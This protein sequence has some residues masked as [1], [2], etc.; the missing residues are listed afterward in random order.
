MSQFVNHLLSNMRVRQLGGHFWQ[1]F[2]DLVIV[3]EVYEEAS[4]GRDHN[5]KWSPEVASRSVVCLLDEGGSHR[6]LVTGYAWFASAV[7]MKSKPLSPCG[8][9][10][11]T[12]PYLLQQVDSKPSLIRGL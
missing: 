5:L 9:S 2:I 10:G 11:S 6:I 3:F 12:Q 1:S 8:F 7:L 4:L